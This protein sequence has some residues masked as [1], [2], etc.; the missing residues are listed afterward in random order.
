MGQT[1][2]IPEP[3]PNEAINKQTSHNHSNH[4]KISNDLMKKNFSSLETY[5]LESTFD[6]LSCLK[7][8]KQKYLGFP[9]GAKI[10]S[11]LYR[12][13]TY[14]AT[15]PSSVHGENLLTLNGLLKAVAVYCDKIHDVILEDRA[16]LIFESFAMHEE[17][18]AS[19]TTPKA[20][21]SYG[22]ENSSHDTNDDNDGEEGKPKLKISSINLDDDAAFLRALGFQQSDDDKTHL[23]S[24]ILC[25]DVVEI[26]AGIIWIMTISNSLSSYKSKEFES[27][28]SI[29]QL[30]EIVTPVVENMA[31]Y[32]SNLRNLSRSQIFSSSTFIKWTIFDDFMRRNIPNIF[33]DFIP[34]FYGQFLIGLTLSQHREESIITGSHLPKLDGKSENLN[35]AN[36]ALLSW[37]LP[38]E[39]LK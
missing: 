33:R 32:D 34:F 9:E 18:S 7:D 1:G 2:S 35:P 27:L 16:K 19:G 29:K 30:H 26:L 14:L 21:F 28:K 17:H 36:L 24:K 22:P 15:Y 25:T 37:M 11:L 38:E 39:T 3:Q 31:R 10:G 5:S 23:V 6:N 13:F 4:D 20:G 12:S 8:D